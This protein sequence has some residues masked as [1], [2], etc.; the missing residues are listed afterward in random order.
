MCTFDRL[1]PAGAG[2]DVFGATVAG[3]FVG[4]GLGLGFGLGL[5]E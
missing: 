4:V 5:D 2:A 1:N 3:F